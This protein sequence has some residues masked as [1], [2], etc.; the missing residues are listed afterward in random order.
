MEVCGT[1]SSNSN[2]INEWRHVSP[3]WQ[4][5]QNMLLPYVSYNNWRVVFAVTGGCQKEYARQFY[6]KCYVACN[7]C[8]ASSI[9]GEGNE[10]AEAF[11]RGDTGQEGLQ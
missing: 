6:Q 8:V 5:T 2:D 1:R 7:R 10:A 4:S 3:D 11:K 9:D